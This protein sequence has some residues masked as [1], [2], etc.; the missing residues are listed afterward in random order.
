MIKTLQKLVEAEHLTREEARSVI[1]RL[2]SGELSPAQI[3]AFLAAMQIK[4]VSTDELVGAAEAMRSKMTRIECD[5]W[6]IVDCCGT[7]G[8][9]SGTFNISTAAAFVVAGAGI[10]VA[11]HGNRS[12]SSRSGS[13]DV[14][15]A[16]EINVSLDPNGIE[17]CL[18]EAGIAFLFAQTLHP[19]MKHVAKARRE[20][21]IKTIFNL[22]GPLTNPAGAQVQ[23]VGV[24]DSR[25][26]RMYAEALRELGCQRAMVVCGADGLD[27]L[28]NTGP[29]HVVELENGE[30]REST[31]DPEVYGLTRAHKSDLRGGKPRE[32]AELIEAVVSGRDHG[33]RRDVVVLNA[34]ALIMLAGNADSLDAGIEAAAAS[35]DGGQALGK[36]DALRW[37]A[38]LAMASPGR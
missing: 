20:L 7:G 18:Q 34:G 29:N 24:F 22:L 5:L 28:S 38:P 3:G 33:P 8:D 9:N 19:A 10:C 1:E 14:L 17:R 25:V 31:L 4:G 15:E 16:L 35:I 2:M 36:L 26:Q 23:L 32:N 37:L 12:V 6:P 21:G 27:E 13:A 11:K 30:L